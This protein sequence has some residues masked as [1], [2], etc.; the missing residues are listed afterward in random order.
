MLVVGVTG[1][2][3]CGKDT[4][5]NQIDKV[6]KLRGYKTDIRRL[7]D[8]LKDFV[9]NLLRIDKHLLEKMKNDNKLICLGLDIVTTRDFIINS[10]TA[11]RDTFGDDFFIEM[12]FKDL[13]NDKIYLIPDVRFK[14]EAEYIKSLNGLIIRL[15]SDL[16][17]CGKNGKRYEVD[18]IKP[19]VNI[20]N[21]AGDFDFLSNEVNKLVDFLETKL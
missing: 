4:I 17:T 21:K 18:E 7:A 12:V 15:H 20:T 8:P 1:Y 10:A 14:R 11:L 2:D 6:L 19:D 5:V 13:D 3:R 16:K 9:S